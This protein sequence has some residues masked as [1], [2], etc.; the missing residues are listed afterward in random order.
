MPK[1]K[2]G[3]FDLFGKIGEFGKDVKNEWEKNKSKVQKTRPTG[4]GTGKGINVK[5]P[6]EGQGGVGLTNPKHDAHVQAWQASRKN[7][8]AAPVRPNYNNGTNAQKAQTNAYKEV[9]DKQSRAYNEPPT[10]KMKDAKPE[11]IDKFG[12]KLDTAHELPRKILKK[13]GKNKKK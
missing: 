8:G 7:K 12:Q 11:I 1:V 2:K 5:T 3:D 9:H 6:G 10:E 13:N 4:R